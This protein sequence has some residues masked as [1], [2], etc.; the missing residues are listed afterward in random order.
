[1]TK[2]LYAGAG[3]APWAVTTGAGFE[4]T[5]GLPGGATVRVNAASAVVGWAFPNLH[6]DVILQADPTGARVGARASYDPFGQPIDPAIGRIGTTTADDTT[7][8]DADYAWVGGAKRLYEHQGSIAAIE[9]GARVFI[10]SLGRFLSIDPVEGGVTNAYDYPSDPI[11]QFD[12]SGN[13]SGDGDVGCNIGMNISAIFVGI[14]DAVTFCPLCMLA[15]ETSFTGVIRNAIG[16]ESAKNAASEIQSNGFYTFGALWGG[17]ATAPVGGAIGSAAGYAA[18]R[19]S[20]TIIVRGITKPAVT[21]VGTLLARGSLTSQTSTLFAR[22][23]GLLNKGYVRIGWNWMG[24]RSNG[25]NVF[26]IGIGPA[27]TRHINI[28]MY[29]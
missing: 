20:E 5:I 3:D 13:C 23:T 24:T 19:A 21:T 28:G 4:A 14:G 6:G 15:G 2:Y 1:M 25:T 9:M 26:R 11:N 8:G 17:A 22:G 7:P 16:G 12:L 10:P 18:A 29:R 27:R